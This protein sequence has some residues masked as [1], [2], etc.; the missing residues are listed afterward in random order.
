YG[1]SSI[2]DYAQ[3]DKKC[4]NPTST[5]FD[6]TVANPN[7]QIVGDDMFRVQVPRCMAWF[8]Y[9]EHVDSLSTMDNEVGVTS[10]KSTTQTL[11]SFEEYTPPVTYPEEVEQTLGTPME[12]VPSFDEPKPQPKPLANFPTL[13]HERNQG[14]SRESRSGDEATIPPDAERSAK[15]QWKTDKFKQILIQVRGKVTTLL[16]DPKK[17]HEKIDFQWTPEAERAFQGMKQCIAELPM[18]TAPR[19]KEEL[20]MYLCAARE[21][22]KTGLSTSTCYKKAE[23]ILPGTSGSS[24]H[25]PTHQIDHVT[26]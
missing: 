20:I 11:P 19:P 25:R 15:P 8:D 22:W 13:D 2:E 24:D 1:Y 21:A 16:Q 14:L 26:I 9:D 3:Y 23:A 10:P 6:E 12:E 18:V 17:V 4:S 5:I 7:A